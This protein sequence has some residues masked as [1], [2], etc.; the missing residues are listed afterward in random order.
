MSET[1]YSITDANKLNIDFYE[2]Y[3]EGFLYRKAE[4]CYLVCKEKES[5]VKFIAVGNSNNI[6]GK[7][8]EGLKGEIYFTEFH[9]F[10]CFFALFLEFCL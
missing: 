9:Q 6:T 5:F 10:E 2:S 7:Y 4:L 8:F 1:N 3:D